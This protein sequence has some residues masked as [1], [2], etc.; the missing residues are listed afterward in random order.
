MHTSAGMYSLS[1]A[2][3]KTIGYINM[4]YF[5]LRYHIALVYAFKYQGHSSNAL[6][7]SV[8]PQSHLVDP[9]VDWLYHFIPTAILICPN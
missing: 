5:T 9:S 1:D 6:T 8:N 7:C 4:C 3:H 2:N